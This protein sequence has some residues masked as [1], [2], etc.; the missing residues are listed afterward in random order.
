MN[1]CLGEKHPQNVGQQ[2]HRMDL[3]TRTPVQVQELEIQFQNLNDHK[4]RTLISVM[5]SV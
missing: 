2:G 1:D 3:S 5:H 4:V